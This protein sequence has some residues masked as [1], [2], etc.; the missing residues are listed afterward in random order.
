MLNVTCR[1]AFYTELVRFVTFC[2][3]AFE[4]TL[5]CGFCVWHPF[6]ASTSAPGNQTGITMPATMSV[7][8]MRGAF[9]RGRGGGGV[10]YG[11]V[12]GVAGICLCCA[13]ACVCA[14]QT[15]MAYGHTDRPV[16]MAGTFPA[17]LKPNSHVISS[18]KKT[19]G[20]RE[21]GRGPLVQESS[22]VFFLS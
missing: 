8:G 21:R 19:E 5:A 20:G 16:G 15:G 1:R 4:D 6:D 10:W 9:P 18:S 11:E 2:V 3:R 14:Y 13:C 22:S 7:K 12:S 17:R